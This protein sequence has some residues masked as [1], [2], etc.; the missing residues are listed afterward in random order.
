MRQTRAVAIAAV[1]LALLAVATLAAP[2]FVKVAPEGTLFFLHVRNVP[3]L[4]E[5]LKTHASFA[6][7]QEP[8]V[9]QFLEAPLARLNEEIR[10]AEGRAGVRLE[11]L[12]DIFQGQVA[13]IVTEGEPVGAAL[14]VEAKGKGERAMDV[15]GALLDLAAERS[16]EFRLQRVEATISGARAVRLFAAGADAPAFVYALAGDTFLVGD[17]GSVERMIGSLQATPERSLESVPAYRDGL[18]RV[19]EDSDVVAFVNVAGLGRLAQRLDRSGQAAPILLALGIE[20]LPGATLGVKVTPE[21]TVQRIFIQ[22]SG[23]QGLPRLLRM[24][25]GPLHEPSDVPPDAATFA[26]YRVDFARLY[27]EIIA[28]L[29]N[30]APQAVAAL[31]MQE[32]QIAQTTGKAFHFRDDIIGVF[33][34]RVSMYSRFEPPYDPIRSQ[35]TVFAVEIRSRAAFEGILNIVGQTAPMALA[36]MQPENYLGWQMYVFRAPTPP[37]APPTTPDMPTPAIAVMED[38]LLFSP[39]SEALRGH[40]RRLGKEGQSLADLPDYQ[41]AMRRLPPDPK[42]MVS[43]ANPRYQVEMFIEMLRSGGSGPLSS[44]LRRDADIAAFLDL[45]DL[46]RLPPAADVTKHLLPGA[47]CALALPDGILIVAD[48]PARQ[49]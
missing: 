1:G 10:K 48:Q 34:P 49:E 5:S 41:K 28:I 20:G 32:Q 24:E 7:W 45:F 2:P 40:L 44:A 15:F 19:G 36:F 18:N 31:E 21:S 33:G 6:V 23:S 22:L 37:N 9:Q 39:N 46:Q 12:A 16:P 14:L 3:A 4:V 13:L 42:L 47:G 29:G 11:E 30:V 27:D 25:P 8:S 43:F 17:A 35:Q 38:R 26:A